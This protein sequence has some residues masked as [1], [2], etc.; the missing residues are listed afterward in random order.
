MSTAGRTHAWPGT[1]GHIALVFGSRKP[2][3][4]AVLSEGVMFYFMVTMPS[5][6]CFASTWWMSEKM[7]SCKSEWCR[8][9][10]FSNHNYKSVLMFCD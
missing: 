3:R 6:C 9:C 1:R 10:Y 7:C 2:A 4:F 8:L 5:R